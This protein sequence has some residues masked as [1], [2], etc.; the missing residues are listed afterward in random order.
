MFFR[1]HGKASIYREHFL[2]KG[3]MNGSSKAQQTSGTE[4]N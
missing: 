3:V 1:I 4:P 2:E